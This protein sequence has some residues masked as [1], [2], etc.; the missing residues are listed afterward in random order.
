M[1]RPAILS[2]EPD[3]PARRAH[4]E[5]MAAVN[6]VHPIA[7]AHDMQAAVEGVPVG[8]RVEFMGSTYRIADKVGLMPLIR[9]ARAARRG[10][11]AADMEGLAAI[12][13]MLEDCIDPE[14]WPRFEA[15][16]TLHKA[17]D[18]DL[19]PVVQQT[20]EL[21]TARPTRRPSGSS[22]GPSTTSPSSTGSSPSPDSPDGAVELVSVDELVRRASG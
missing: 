15:D 8:D 11:D 17:D 19:L 1:A 20:I 21:L 10:T 12:G 9:F 16:A 7:T 22:D 4:A 18:T 5:D 3:E 14:D 6:P 13:D 2:G